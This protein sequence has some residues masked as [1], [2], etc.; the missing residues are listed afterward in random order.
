MNK[1]CLQHILFPKV[2][3]CTEM[4]LYFR[5]N[6]KEKNETNKYIFDGNIQL[7][8]EDTLDFGTYFN[9][10]SYGIWRRYSDID[11]INLKLEVKGKFKIHI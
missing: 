11:N 10:F 3:I 5:N 4:G 6:D 2:E 1:Q 9:S 7:D 8:K